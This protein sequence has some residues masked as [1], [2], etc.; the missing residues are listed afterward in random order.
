MASSIESRQED[1]QD[2]FNFRLQ[3][4]SEFSVK[5]ILVEF[6]EPQG[7]WKHTFLLSH[8]E[9]ITTIKDLH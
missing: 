7:A 3:I 5:F 9:L 2:A 6:P 4:K 1:T 8:S